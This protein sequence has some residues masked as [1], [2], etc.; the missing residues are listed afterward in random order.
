VDGFSFH[1][2][3]HYLVS[4]GGLDADG[5]W[6]YSRPDFLV[7]VQALSMLLRAK[8]RD[9]LKKAELLANL[10][11][12][13]WQKAWVLHCEGVGSGKTAFKYLAPYIFRVAISNNRILKLED[14]QVTFQYKDSASK[15]MK[16]ATLSAE[17]FMRRFLAH[18]LPKRF[19]KVRA[20]GLLSPSH[21]Y[22]LQLARTQLGVAEIET[23]TDD[24]DLATAKENDSTGAEPA[25]TL[26]CPS[27]GSRLIV[28]E[29]V[30]RQTRESRSRKLP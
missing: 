9:E 22:L 12:R 6:H 11:T 29:K 13:L 3:V 26:C 25:Q 24:D 19:I 2:H 23:K 4:G 15:Q 10:D 27:C 7:P 16:S 8:V 21:R 14:G 17:E 28:V 18:V 20:Y 1:P 30:P 5:L